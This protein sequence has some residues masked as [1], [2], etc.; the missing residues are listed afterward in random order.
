MRRIVLISILGVLCHASLASAFITPFGQRVDESISRGLDYL[1]TTQGNDGGWGGAT[2]L[3]TLCFLEQRLSADWNAPSRGYVGMEPDDQQRV[4][5]AI[6][7]CINNTNGFGNGRTPNAYSA[8]ACLM[9]MSLYIGTGGPD[10]VGASR[11]VLDALRAGIDNMVGAQGNC[12]TNREAGTT[13]IVQAVYVMGIYPP[14]SS[15][16]P[17]CPP[18]QRFF[19]MLTSHC[20]T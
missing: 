11:S 8:G 13:L 3:A 2:G 7:Y 16:W 17:V 12:G 18:Q 15:A 4:R 14:H 5:N 9:A 1:R 10:D 19:R 6:R 20:R